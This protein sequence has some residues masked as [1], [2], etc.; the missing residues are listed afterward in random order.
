[1]LWGLLLGR[2]R[3][4]RSAMRIPIGRVAWKALCHGDCYWT[5]RAGGAA[6][7]GLLL[8]VALCY[9][10]CGWAC[11]LEGAVLWGLLLGVSRGSVG[12]VAWGGI[13]L[14]GFILG[15]SRVLCYEDYWWACRVGGVVALGLLNRAS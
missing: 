2:S 10:D 12:H 5:C 9:G 6:L 7:W 15:E 8:G 13:G 4:W 11:R 14:W 3:G 1:M